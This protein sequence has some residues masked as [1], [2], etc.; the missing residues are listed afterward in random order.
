MLCPCGIQKSFSNCCEN[1]INGNETA[2]SPE[3]LMRSRYSAYA[4]KN[5]TY[6]FNTYANKSRIPQSIE[7]ID[8]WA[9]ET[10][11]VKLIIH[12]RSSF[13]QTTN[14][15]ENVSLPTV[16]FSA[17][18]VH[19]HQLFKMRECSNFIYEDNNW[20]YLNGSVTRNEEVNKPKRN[21]ICF[22]GSAKKFKQCCAKQF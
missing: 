19:Q 18:Y 22:C 4:T 6:V 14:T 16:E 17:F 5:S 15:S 11:W 7:D 13:R 21:D 10:Q 1:I 12:H 20:R 8:S 3:Q 9:Q 2:S